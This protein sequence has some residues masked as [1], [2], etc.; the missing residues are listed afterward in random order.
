MADNYE[1]MIERG[2][3]DD[4][5]DSFLSSI[6]YGHHEQS[7]CW[8]K[9]K[10]HQGWQA[11]R[12]K[13]IQNSNIIAGAQMLCKRLPVGGSVG[14]ISSGPCYT[15]SDSRAL[16]VL[17]GS[18]NQLARKNKIRYLAITPYIED[19]ALSSLLEQSGY[20]FTQ[21]ILPPV[22]TTRA[23]LI[24]DLSKD[25]DLLFA[26]M[27]R[28]TRREINLA[29]RSGF[30][31]R[32][33]QREDLQILFDLMA[34][35]AKRRGE[36]PTPSSVVFFEHIW[37]HFHP[38]GF[39]KLFLIES[40]GDPVSAGLIFT[41]G[42]TARFWKYGWSGGLAK[43][44]PNHLLYWELIKWSKKNKFRYMDIVQVDSRV[45]DHLAAGCPVT[46]ELK[47]RRLYGPTFFKTGFGGKVVKF[48]GPWFR[49]GNPFLAYLYGHF[50]SLFFRKPYL[51]KLI[52][53]I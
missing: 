24:L 23:T 26:D 37:D 33:G 5:W 47:S 49:F 4:Q 18:I 50:G 53:R 17:F 6:E 8:A 19:H 42:R 1:I 14:Y 51:K 20:G 3:S 28:E 43:K 7:T 16:E 52:S 9:V 13:V 46:D 32:E 27:R 10:E 41:F 45:T 12:L 21:E 44:Y 22:A 48:S 15:G 2:A 34:M 35:T 25:T 39:V 11:I 40:G 30:T 29:S 31:V 36:N 38:D